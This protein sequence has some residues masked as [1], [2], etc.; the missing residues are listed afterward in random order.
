MTGKQTKRIVGIQFFNSLHSNN[1][2]YSCFMAL[3]CHDLWT[4]SAASTR[5]I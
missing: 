4:L 2:S 5:C 1:V 3:L